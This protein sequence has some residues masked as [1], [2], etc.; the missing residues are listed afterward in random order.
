[1]SFGPGGDIQSH[2]TCVCVSPNPVPK[3]VDKSLN[4]PAKAHAC[5]A[6]GVCLIKQQLAGMARAQRTSPQGLVLRLFLWLRALLPSC[7]R[8]LF[9]FAGALFCRALALNLS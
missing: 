9:G 8:T 2:A 6:G 4:K 1:M 5:W 7:F 3:A